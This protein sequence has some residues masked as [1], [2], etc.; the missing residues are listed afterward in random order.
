MSQWSSACLTNSQRFGWPIQVH[1]LWGSSLSIFTHWLFCLSAL[2]FLFIM[3]RGCLATPASCSVID[4]QWDLYIT[5]KQ[6][7]RGGQWW[8]SWFWPR[9]C[10]LNSHGPPAGWHK[11]DGSLRAALLIGSAPGGPCMPL[12]LFLSFLP[13]RGGEVVE[14]KQGGRD[15]ERAREWMCWNVTHVPKIP[16]SSHH[17]NIPLLDPGKLS[18][19]DSD[20]KTQT[21]S[22]GIKWV[23]AEKQINSPKRQDGLQASNSFS[24]FIF[25]LPNL[26]L[27][28][29]AL[30]T[31]MQ[32]FLTWII[33]TSPL[34]VPLSVYF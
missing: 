7:T 13:R 8:V 24:S 29:P 20:I 9:I 26:Q 3:H 31:I 11:A 5:D 15:N 33:S 27:T 28:Q 23:T 17:P 4:S 25:S 14:E 12:F 19:T 10:V 6:L 16:D 32:V 18:W 21:C 2:L 22:R 1:D 34:C 30:T